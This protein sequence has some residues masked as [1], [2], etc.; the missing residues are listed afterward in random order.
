MATILLTALNTCLLFKLLHSLQWQN[1]VTQTIEKCQIPLA[2]FC[3]D[4]STLT[5]ADMFL[6]HFCSLQKFK[7][8][9]ANTVISQENSSLASMGTDQ[10]LD[11]FSLD[12]NSPSAAAS[13]CHSNKGS[14]SSQSGSLKNVLE[15]MDELWDVKQYED[16]YD[17]GSFMQGLGK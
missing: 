11:L 15:N 8:N 3:N 9:I 2:K 7:L 12:G 1:A 14:T 6:T 10:L 5:K 4:F 13:T 16:E 17:L